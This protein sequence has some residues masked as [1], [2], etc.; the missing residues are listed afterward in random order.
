MSLD[1]GGTTNIFSPYKS[2]TVSHVSYINDKKHIYFNSQY[3]PA[4][5]QGVANTNENLFF[6]VRYFQ[7]MIIGK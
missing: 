1:V 4:G 6:I 5:I 7:L 2:V 3:I